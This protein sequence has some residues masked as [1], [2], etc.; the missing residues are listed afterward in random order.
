LATTLLLIGCEPTGWVAH[1]LT[2]N[3]Y[4]IVIVAG[5]FSAHVRFADHSTELR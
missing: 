5:A 1:S 3:S 4:N 2:T